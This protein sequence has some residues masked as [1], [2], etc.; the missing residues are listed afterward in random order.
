M[1]R[2]AALRQKR[3]MT[4]THLWLIH[5]YY[6]S[7]VHFVSPTEDNQYQ[8]RKMKDHGLMRALTYTVSAG[9]VLLVLAAGS[10][11]AGNA[12]DVTYYKDVLPILQENCQTCHRPTG[13][14]NI[15]GL[16]APMSFMNYQETR[17]WARA[18]ARKVE[19]HE[20]PPW[21]ADAP[22]GV[23]NNE[24]GL[25]DDEIGTLVAWAAGGAA[26]GEEADAP[27]ARDF[28]ADNVDGWSNGT[29]DFIIT[30][31]E[32]YFV[33]DDIYDLNISFFTKLTEAKL[34]EDTWV[35][36]WEFNTGTDGSL[37][38]H[39]CAFATGPSDGG[40]LAGAAEGEAAAALGGL[41][42]CMAE[43]AAANSGM[44]PDGYGVQ[45][46]TGGTIGWNVH[47][48]KE[49]QRDSG[50]WSQP[51][52]GFYVAAGPPQYHVKSD[53]IGN[54]AFE[55]PPNH[56]HYRVGSSRTLEKDTMVLNYWPHAHLRAHAAR[57]VATYPDGR[58][59]V[60]LDVPRYDQGW[61]ETYTYREPK[62]LPKGTRIDVSFW[63]DNTAARAEKMGF[64]PDRVVW[65]GP[66]TDDEMSL[67]FI[68][69]A[70]VEPAAATT[71]QE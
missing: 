44:L 56:P 60:L 57:Y 67:G 15:G 4:L 61:Q 54:S 12:E 16:T 2:L 63:F 22:R 71:Q 69:Y 26:R 62:L 46:K 29:P 42:S 32:P 43:G 66:R 10:A 13:Q 49:P 47:Y 28:M 55:I 19:A 8:T 14:Y 36:G 50:E 38:H 20:M 64:N 41:L 11:V 6:A 51:K 53:P 25:T 40:P 31:D 37:V 65:Q 39:M 48:H 58:E 30:L 34:P 5:R 3:L 18:I 9:A 33:E 52:I 24:R 35:R 23:F 59:E 70:E 45:L 7:Q 68:G 27:P 1:T 17:P 21:F